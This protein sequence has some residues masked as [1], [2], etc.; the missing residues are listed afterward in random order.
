MNIQKTSEYLGR[1]PRWVRQNIHLIPHFRLNGQILLDEA[2]LRKW[3]LRF[4]VEPADIDIAG[5]L[6]KVIPCQPRRPR[7][8]GGRFRGGGNL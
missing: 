3:M 1:S 7:E 5:I 6:K 2:D 8:K 4:R